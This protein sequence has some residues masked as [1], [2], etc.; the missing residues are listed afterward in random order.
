MKTGT[1]SRPITPMEYKRR[2]FNKFLTEAL[3]RMQTCVLQGSETEPLAES[4]L[5]DIRV[6]TEGFYADELNLDKSTISQ[7]RRRLSEADEFIH[8]T[9]NTAEEIAEEKKKHV[10]EDNIQVTD[11]QDIELSDE[12]EEIMD[13]L[14]DLKKPDPQI[15]RIRNATVA[16]LVAEDQKSQ[17]IKQA[18]EIAQKQDEEKPGTMEEAVSRINKVGPTSLMNGIINYFSTLA[19]RSVNEAGNMGSISNVLSDNKEI[20]KDRAAIMYS[21]FETASVMGIH[22]YTDTEVKKLTTEF[23]NAKKI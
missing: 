9:M 20:I 11:D 22:R 16:A 12:D 2:V 18:I 15:D 14:F 5:K 23:Y 3:I 19:V 13:Q 8:S 7:T 21:L 4:V 10:E 6:F 1:T 17:E